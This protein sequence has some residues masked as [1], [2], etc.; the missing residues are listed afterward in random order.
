MLTDLSDMLN[1]KALAVE[2][3]T[4]ELLRQMRNEMMGKAGGYAPDGSLL[5][6]RFDAL[7]KAEV[8]LEK[9]LDIEHGPFQKY[10]AFGREFF[11]ITQ[12]AV[13]PDKSN[14]PIRLE[15]VGLR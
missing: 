12:I 11:G 10:R 4:N 14:V 3:A 5:R 2:T 6:N 9:T 15:Q 8:D 1:N 13:E 7:D